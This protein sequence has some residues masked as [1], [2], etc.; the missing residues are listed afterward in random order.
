M[1]DAA[2]ED[3]DLHVVRAGLAAVDGERRQRLGGGL[4]GI[5]A[6][7]AHIR[8]LLKERMDILDSRN[9]RNWTTEADESRERVEPA[10]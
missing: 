6:N 1:T 10:G 9:G 8:V 7:L 3:V 4:G 5:S 2:I